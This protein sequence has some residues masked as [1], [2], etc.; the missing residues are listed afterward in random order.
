MA[1]LRPGVE[2][3]AVVR[4]PSEGETKVRVQVAGRTIT[5]LDVPAYGWYEPSFVIPA[6][7]ASGATPISLR[8]EGEETFGSAHYWFYAAP[9]APAPT[10]P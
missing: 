7:L 5:E 4:I 9:A 2:T 6:D 3:I 10:A 8:V 1:H